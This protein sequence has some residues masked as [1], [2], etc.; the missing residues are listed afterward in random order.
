[1]LA[2]FVRERCG[3]RARDVKAQLQLDP[4]ILRCLSVRDYAPHHAMLELAL[5]PTLKE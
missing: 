1:M 2:Y 4:S 5:K 3:L